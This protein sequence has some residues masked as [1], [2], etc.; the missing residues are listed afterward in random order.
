MDYILEYLKSYGFTINLESANEIVI[1]AYCILVI[2]LIILSCTLNLILYFSFLY[3]LENT[4]FKNYI[5][6]KP[7]LTKFVLF[8][9]NTRFIYIIFE[10]IIII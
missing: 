1:F 7:F 9:K 2:G 4:R 6:N 8:Y 5:S 10:F 3:G